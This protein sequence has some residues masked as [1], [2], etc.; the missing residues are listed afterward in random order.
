MIGFATQAADRAAFFEFLDSHSCVFAAYQAE[1]SM[2]CLVSAVGVGSL[3][4]QIKAALWQVNCDLAFHRDTRVNNLPFVRWAPGAQLQGSASESK[5]WS[6]WE[7]AKFKVNFFTC[8]WQCSCTFVMFFDRF[9]GM[10]L[11]YVFSM[12]L[13]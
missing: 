12:L 4:F 13:Y 5:N 6:D 10:F 11:L 7:A 2:G 3:F 1:Q 8:T 9:F